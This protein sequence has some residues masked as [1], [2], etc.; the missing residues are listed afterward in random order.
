MA[1]IFGAKVDDKTGKVIVDNGNKENALGTQSNAVG[2]SSL[3]LLTGILMGVA[4]KYEEKG[5]E[6]EDRL[7]KAAEK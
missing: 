7:G 1:Q 3:G 4:K 6:A 2:G 5:V